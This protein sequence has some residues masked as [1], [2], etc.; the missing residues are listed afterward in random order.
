MHHLRCVLAVLATIAVLAGFRAMPA[1]AQADVNTIH[2]EAPVSG[3]ISLTC[4][5][6]D[7]SFQG[8]VSGVEHTTI[9][10]AGGNHSV[11]HAGELRA[12]GVGLTTGQLY[13]LTGG[14]QDT[15]GLFSSDGPIAITTVFTI[16]YISQGGG[17]N[18]RQVEVVH[19]TRDANG[20]VV[21][22]VDRILLDKCG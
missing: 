19:L 8:T 3:I 16:N 1:G 17:P 10:A 20:D 22:D 18:Y 14:T 6:E 7:V 9:D 11:G 2:E 13:I 12:T 15:A 21:L 5:G 4:F